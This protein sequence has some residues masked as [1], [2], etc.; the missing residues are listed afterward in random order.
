MEQFHLGRVNLKQL[1]YALK[2]LYNLKFSRYL[3]VPI[4][5]VSIILF[6]FYTSLLEVYKLTISIFFQFS[7]MFLTIFF[8]TFNSTGYFFECRT[9]TGCPINMKGLEKKKHFIWQEITL[10]HF[11]V[12]LLSEYLYRIVKY[13]IRDTTIRVTIIGGHHYPGHHYRGSALSGPPLSGVAI[14]GLDNQTTNLV[15]I[16]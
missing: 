8:Y 15:T 7:N 14:I 13:I 2:M 9:H 12:Y 3:R 11:K 5:T 6:Y 16:N 10:P 4:E 1:I